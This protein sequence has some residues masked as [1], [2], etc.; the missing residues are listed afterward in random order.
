MRKAAECRFSKVIGNGKDMRSGFRNSS[1]E[2]S[3]G[4]LALGFGLGVQTIG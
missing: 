3:H 2:I 1:V 4:G